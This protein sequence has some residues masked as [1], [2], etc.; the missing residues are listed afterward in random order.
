M[1]FLQGRKTLFSD[2]LEK[3]RGVA[4]YGQLEGL[5]FCRWI[6]FVYTSFHWYCYFSMFQRVVDAF[7]KREDNAAGFFW[8]LCLV[9]NKLIDHY[10]SFC[11]C[12]KVSRICSRDSQFSRALPFLLQHERKREEIWKSWGNAYVRCLCTLFNTI[13]EV[14]MNQKLYRI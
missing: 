5:V 9:S 7:S 6:Q 12:I 13:S 1:D 10:F 2:R 3:P 4:A 8:E 14:T 11:V